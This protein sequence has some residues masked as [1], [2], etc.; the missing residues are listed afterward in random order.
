MYVLDIRGSFTKEDNQNHES[1]LFSS[2][3]IHT[4]PLSPSIPSLLSLSSYVGT[5]SCYGALVSTLCLGQPTPSIHLSRG[6][7]INRTRLAYSGFLNLAGIESRVDL[8]ASEQHLN[9]VSTGYEQGVNGISTVYEQNVQDL[10]NTLF[11][12]S[13]THTGF[14]AREVQK[15]RLG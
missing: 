4:S 11:R 8:T 1:S 6:I 7:A 2:P 14:K 13:E 3:T 12:R 10:V 5:F 15:P 9:R